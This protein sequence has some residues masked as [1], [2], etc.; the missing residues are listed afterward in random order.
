MWRHHEEKLQALL[1]S[2]RTAGSNDGG[3]E[4]V[5]LRVVNRGKVLSAEAG[6]MVNVQRCKP[7]RATV[8]YARNAIATYEKPAERSGGGDNVENLGLVKY[9]A[10]N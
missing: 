8:L 10:H 3:P 1:R 6:E 4:R 7:M 2:L 9:S 5:V